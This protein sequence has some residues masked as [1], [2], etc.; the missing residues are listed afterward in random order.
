[1]DE[2]E[3]FLG[4]GADVLL[5]HL[6]FLPLQFWPN[7]SF[8]RGIHSTWLGSGQ[9]K[10]PISLATGMGIGT[11][12]VPDFSWGSMC[13]SWERVHLFTLEIMN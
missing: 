11:G 7:S 6:S 4:L 10:C 1:M 13:R 5:T 2:K 9:S 12:A 3:S 8:L